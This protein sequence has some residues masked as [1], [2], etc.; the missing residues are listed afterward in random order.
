MATEL[1]RG[2]SYLALM[3]P[4]FQIQEGLE[5]L[6]N[7]TP[8]KLWPQGGHALLVN[9]PTRSSLFECPMA[10]LFLPGMVL[11]RSAQPVEKGEKDYCQ[12]RTH[13]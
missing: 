5:V 13:Q 12:G 3:R 1:L 7:L 4:T 9:A 6:S 8:A 11:G 2:G 10:E